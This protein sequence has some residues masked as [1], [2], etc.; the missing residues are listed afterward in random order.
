MKTSN[1][2]SVLMLVYGYAQ[3]DPRV[4]RA[5]KTVAHLGYDVT[6]IGAARNGGVPAE[7][8]VDNM[9]IILTPIFIHLKLINILLMLWNLLRGDVGTVTAKPSSDRSGIRSAFTVIFY[10]LWVIRLAYS[11][12]YD[13]IHCHD[14]WPLFPARF[15]SSRYGVPLIYDAH[16]S[17]QDMYSGVKNKIVAFIE[18]VNMRYADSVITV[19]KRLKQALDKR[20][21]RN[22]IIVGNWRDQAEYTPDTERLNAKRKELD[23]TDKK[24][25]VS[26]LGL[27][28]AERDLE[29]LLEAVSTTPDVALVIG[30]RGEMQNRIVDYA[31]RYDNIHWLG[32]VNIGDVAFYNQLGD[33]IYYCLNPD[34]CEQ[35]FYSTPNKLFESFAAGKAMIARKGVG[36]ISEILE[37]TES[38]VLLDTVTPDTLKVAFAQLSEPS[39][40]SGLQERARNARLLYDWSVAEERLRDLYHDLIGPPQPPPAPDSDPMVQ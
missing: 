13:L 1:G 5:G 10:N 38:A 22:V 4:R 30:G 32:W 14:F 24:L 11:Q 25:V 26:Y 12:R 18:E 34:L 16:E 31:V 17:V 9:R 27:L 3:D 23:L 40:L 2:K 39:T 35:S 36:E 8:V 6:V 33:V 19:G 15:L 37:E 7:E 21:A 28:L 29:P 20:G